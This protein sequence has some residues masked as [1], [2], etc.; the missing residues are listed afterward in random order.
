MEFLFYDIWNLWFKVLFIFAFMKTSVKVALGTALIWII[1]TLIAFLAGYSESF[2]VFGILLNIFLLL[3]AIA[4]GLFFTRKETGFA[5]SIFLDDFKTALQSGLVYALIIAAFVYLYHATIDTSIRQN[6]VELRMEAIHKMVPDEA[7]F[8]E[9][10]ENDPNFLQWK[11]KGYDDYMENQ[12][13]SIQGIISAFSV[14]IFHL[15]G[16]FIF[17]M[18][19]AFFGTI[20]IRK[21]VLRQ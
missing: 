3:M 5:P 11:D 4:A 6:L 8:K 7:T 12:E 1:I 10:Q 21:V 16:L 18:F 9:L 19:F 13:M 14:F 17:S 2:F 20:I 15:M